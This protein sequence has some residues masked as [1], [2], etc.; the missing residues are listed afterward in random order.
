MFFVLVTIKYCGRHNI[1]DEVNPRKVHDGNIPRLGGIGIF[2]SFVIVSAALLFREGDFI[3]Y[4]PVF[5]AFTLIFV[6]ALLDDLRNLR[7]LLKLLF[8][9]IAALMV[10]LSQMYF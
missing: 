2:L 4:L 3:S 8:Q 1:Y 10:A 9:V 5:L 6:F 7:A